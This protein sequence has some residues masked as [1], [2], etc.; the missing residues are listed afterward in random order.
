MFLTFQVRRFEYDKDIKDV[1]L[2]DGRK[3]IVH[4]RRILWIILNNFSEET[5]GLN[6]IQI[7]QNFKNSQF[8]VDYR[9]KNGTA[10]IR[11]KSMF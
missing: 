3:K 9:Q 4:H 7:L 5:I 10:L 8:G 1:H 2:V 11:N 6:C